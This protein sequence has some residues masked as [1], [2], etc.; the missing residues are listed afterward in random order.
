[1]LDESNIFVHTI[2]SMNN[3]A[4]PVERH[5][6]SQNTRVCLRCKQN[7]REHN[8]SLCMECFEYRHPYCNL[9]EIRRCSYNEGFDGPNAFC[10]TC[11]FMNNGSKQS[12]PKLAQETDDYVPLTRPRATG[13]NSTTIE[14]PHEQQAKQSMEQH[15][16]EQHTMEQHTMEQQAMER[17]VMDPR[18]K[19]STEQHATEQQA[20]RSTEQHATEQQAKQSVVFPIPI[21]KTT[22]TGAVDDMIRK[23]S[24]KF[25]QDVGYHPYNKATTLKSYCENC[26]RNTTRRVIKRIVQPCNCEY[27]YEYCSKCTQNS[28]R[29]VKD[30]V[31]DP[32]SHSLCDK[33]GKYNSNYLSFRC[34]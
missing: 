13:T 4:S 31:V 1:M 32:C 21:E 26:K 30:G 18:V 9:C 34:C 14:Q 19:R 22:T 8:R 33:C 6:S 7:K 16:M 24:D 20:K 10:N 15:T 28:P 12:P 11:L 25:K 27:V 3:R 5:H 2:M 17:Q 23:C 29:T